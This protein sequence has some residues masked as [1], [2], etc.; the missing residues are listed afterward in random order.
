M[1]QINV[2]KL[3]EPGFRGLLLLLILMR[4]QYMHFKTNVTGLYPC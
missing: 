3:K 1:K 4:Q 2:E